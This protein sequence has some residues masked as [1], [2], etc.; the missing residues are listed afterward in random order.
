MCFLFSTFAG[1][2]FSGDYSEYFG[3]HVDEESLVYLMLANQMLHSLCPDYITIAEDVSGMPGLCCPIE[4]GGTGFDYRLAMAVPDKW[5]RSARPGSH[6][7]LRFAQGRRDFILKLAT[8]LQQKH[9]DQKTAKL[10]A[11][12]TQPGFC[13]ASDTHAR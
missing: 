8:A 5:I 1:T 3:L 2:G 10:Q 11:A 7:F 4:E 9:F 13:A 6:Q 12:A